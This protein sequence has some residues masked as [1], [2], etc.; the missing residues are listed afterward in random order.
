MGSNTRTLVFDI[1]TSGHEPWH[2]DAR[3]LC[4]S[5]AEGHFGPVQVDTDL[6][7]I[8][9]LLADPEVVKVTHTKYDV[10]YLRLAGYDVQGPVHDTQVMAW[11]LNENT[12]LDLEFLAQKYCGIEMDKRIKRVSGVPHFTCDDGRLV[13]LVDAPMDQLLHYNKGDIIATQKLYGVL[14]SLLDEAMW[15]DYWLDEEVP[16]T[17]TLLDMEHAGLPYNEKENEVLH[18]DLGV[19]LEQQAKQLE[20]MLGYSINWGSA[21]QLREVLFSKIWHQEATIEHGEDLRKPTLVGY[22]AKA[23]DMPKSKV[24]DDDVERLKENIV[25]SVTPKG[26]TVLK[27]TPKNLIGFYTRKGYGLKKTPLSE[28]TKKPSTATPE[29]LYLHAGHEF[30]TELVR[31]RKLRKVMTTYTGVFPEKG[32]GGRIYGRFNQTGTKTGRLSSSGPN[33]QNIPAHGDLGASVRGLFQG[34]LVIGDYSQLEPRLMAH[35]SQDPVLLDTYRSGK[36]IYLVTAEGIF[37]RKVSKEDDERQIAKTLILALGYGAGAGKLA[38]ILALNGYPTTVATAKGYLDEL[39]RL[40]A[41]LFEWKDGVIGFAKRK[42]YVKTIG[43]RH[44]RVGAAFKQAWN[45]KTVGYGERQAVNAVVQ[46]SAADIV[47]RTMVS[48]GN[49]PQLRL[50]AQVHDELI[51][52]KHGHLDASV[53][54]Y[55]TGVATTPGYEL[56]VPLVFEPSFCGSWAD[57]GGKQAVVLEAEDVE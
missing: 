51:W 55:L 8:K 34:D 39:Q 32:F 7:A 41:G 33:L 46:G 37:G 13:P 11:V 18:A 38:Q 28:K 35:Y 30:V 29:L 40:Y 48:L 43:G 19:Q 6:T 16:F 4:V 24:D 12:P 26:F 21:D 22:I 17:S 44:R 50:L 25:A 5:W 36:D 9:D 53:L 15:L 20:D 47:R 52:E 14:W 31:W 2:P 10:R 23:H 56:S 27:V 1:E 42:G 3:L 57:K 54:G 49:E 45:H